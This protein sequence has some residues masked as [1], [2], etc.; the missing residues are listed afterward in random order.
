M[1]RKRYVS[2]FVDFFSPSRYTNQTELKSMS[3]K[4]RDAQDGFA[5]LQ[6]EIAS[7]NQSHSLE[8]KA[9]SEQNEMAVSRLKNVEEAESKMEEMQRNWKNELDQQAAL[10]R[11]AQQNYENE[12]VKHAEATTAL[13]AVRSQLASIQEE[14]AT[15]EAQAQSARNQL[16]SSE[17]SW[18]SQKYTYEHEIENLKDRVNEISAQNDSLIDQLEKANSRRPIGEEAESTGD[19]ERDSTN[20]RLIAYLRQEKA[21]ALTNQTLAQQEAARLKQQLEHTL[22]ALDE[23]K[24]SIETERQRQQGA[25]Q[26]GQEV[27]E[28]KQKLNDLNLLRESND[29][30]RSQSEFYMKKAATLEKELQAAKDSLVPLEDKLRNAS[31][32]SDA[33]SKEI[34]LLRN[35]NDKWKTRSQRALEASNSVDPEELKS[36]EA[37]VNDLKKVVANLEAERDAKVTELQDLL[38]RFDKLK[39]ESQSKLT[40]RRNELVQVKENFSKE[41]EALKTELSTVKSELTALQ[42]QNG[43][44]A[45]QNDESTKQ[46]REELSNLKQEL[47][48]KNAAISETSNKEAENTLLAEKQALIDSANKQIADL[49]EKVATLEKTS[50]GGDSSNVEQLKQEK[51]TLSKRVNELVQQIEALRSSLKDEFGRP[52]DL[53]QAKKNWAQQWNRENIAKLEER[54]KKQLEEKAASLEQEYKAKIEAVAVPPAEAG[55]S[56]EQIKEAMQKGREAAAKELAMRMKLVQSKVEKLT[57]DNRALNEELAKLKATSS[58]T[59]GGVGASSLGFKGKGASSLPV[60]SVRFGG[61]AGGQQSNFQQRLGRPAL[62]KPSLLKPDDANPAATA[63]SNQTIGKRPSNDP[64]A[65]QQDTKRHKDND[66]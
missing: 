32:E 11:Q 28:L 6:E 9:L 49:Q 14:V 54:S 8:V 25:A 17:S 5:K 65:S 64:T 27:E 33:K 45:T 30:L 50:S 66:K 10:S 20:A 55:P 16:A 44:Q 62:Q 35:E 37:E 52:I 1:L 29:S 15:Y 48:A 22:V 51:E 60:A 3:D 38:T 2:I 12:L 63:T 13:Q 26:A 19:N 18:E 46:L 61:A 34:E 43:A 24:L 59:G 47:E 39:A 23:A 53:D 41:V 57:N 42:E 7:I 36:L 4:L 31:S 21:I 56:E 40:R 58:G